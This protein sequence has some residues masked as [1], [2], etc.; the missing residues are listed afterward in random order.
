M[1]LSEEVIK[2]LVLRENTITIFFTKEPVH[3]ILYGDNFGSSTCFI[4]RKGF[5]YT[6]FK[7]KKLLEGKVFWTISI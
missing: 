6:L 1:A 3:P 4:P 7:Q 5:H 2:Y